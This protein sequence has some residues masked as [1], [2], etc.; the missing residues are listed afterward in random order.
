MPTKKISEPDNP[1][2]LNAP[3]V[4][5]EHNPP[6]M[7]VFEPGTYEHECPSCGVKTVFVVP[8]ITC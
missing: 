5:P 7:M 1:W 2:G 6:N 4:H 8:L 3:C